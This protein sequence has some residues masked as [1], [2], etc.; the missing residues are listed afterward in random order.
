MTTVSQAV[1]QRQNTPGELI[2]TYSSSF[3][4]VLPSHIKPD[5]W[6]RLAQGALK[7]G[8]RLDN[9]VF[10]LEA[11]AANNPGAFLAALLDAAR[12]GLEPGTEAYYLTPRKVKGQLEILGIVGY[13]G[14]IDLMYRS[15]AVASVTVQVV[16]ENDHY[17]FVRG[18]HRAPIHRFPNFGREAA[19]GPLVGVY[20]Y[21]ELSTGSVSQVVELNQDD[22][23]RIRAVN[24]LS[25]RDYS[26]WVKWEKDM[27]MKSAA[28]QLRKWVP[29]SP[30]FRKE[31][32]RAAAEVQRVVAEPAMPPGVDTPQGDAIDG[33]LVDDAE[34]WPET[35][36]IPGGTD[37]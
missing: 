15:G 12:L 18:V 1:A 4:T 14:Y 29:T 36:P 25:D 30:E 21:A 3:A 20:A 34:A 5:T 19:R 2:K 28:R 26:P 33:E 24:P 10:E 7:K 6:V 35:A 32:A 16:R 27:W 31:I 8:K 23:D 17:E 22:I 9:G 37:A 11:A 13:Q